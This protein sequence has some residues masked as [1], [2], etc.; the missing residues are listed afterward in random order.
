MRKPL[1]VVLFPV[2]LIAACGKLP[3]PTGPEAKA[4]PKGTLYGKELSDAKPMKISEVVARV[5][6]LE[7]KQVKVE[8]LV[9]GVCA[10]RGCWFKMASDKE[11]QSMQFKVTDGVIIF[12]MSAK[13]K[14]AVA[15]G[16]VEKMVLSLEAT[17][18]Y[19]AHKAEEAGEEFDPKSV[20]EPMTIIRLQ[21]TGAV[22]SDRKQP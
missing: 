7:G 16:T 5:D 20:T 1:T 2:L 22:I 19:L 21:G 4:A 13:G 8:G 18:K 11:F 17:Q 6:E 14:Y 15:E 10:K 12:P 3:E 9:T